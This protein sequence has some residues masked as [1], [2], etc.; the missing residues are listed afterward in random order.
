MNYRTGELD[1]RITFQKRQ[2]VSDG[3]GG[4]TDTWVNITTLSSVWA[5]VRPKSGKEN[6]DFQRVN[7]EASYI[8]VV[9][10][11]SDILASYR[12]VWDGEPF[13]ISAVLKPKSRSL[14]MEI[15][16]ERGVP[17]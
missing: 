1:Q 15:D 7:A 10:N 4:S 8:F 17:Q 2:R 5:H 13:N 6:K 3:M 12:I 14:Y 16:G 9:R 11:R